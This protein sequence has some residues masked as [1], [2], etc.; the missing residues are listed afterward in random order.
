LKTTY[1]GWL[2]HAK[3]EIK[4]SDGNVW[5][6]IPLAAIV[7][8]T[9]VRLKNGPRVSSRKGQNAA[10]DESVERLN[11]LTA[12]NAS[13]QS[14]INDLEARVRTLEK[15]ATDPSRRLAD[16]IERLS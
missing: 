13:L 6:I 1:G 12:H 14:R 5:V 10:S 11:S 9:I 4:M 2:D 15:I 7:G 8:L 3:G 16:E